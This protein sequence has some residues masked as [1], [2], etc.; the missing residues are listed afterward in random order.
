M[1]RTATLDELEERVK[2]LEGD[3]ASITQVAIDLNRLAD[4]VY[5][6]WKLDEEGGEVPGVADVMHALERIADALEKV[7][8]AMAQDSYGQWYLRTETVGAV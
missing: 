1:E 6:R 2:Q 4:N 5:A 3:N 7:S 8:G